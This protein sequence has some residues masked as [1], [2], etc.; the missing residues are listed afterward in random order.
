ME[1]IGLTPGSLIGGYTI[2]APLGSGGMGTVYRAVDGGG[3]PVALKLLHPHVAS[4]AVVRARLMR[5]VAALQRLRHRAVAAVLD[6]EADSTEAFIVTELVAGDTLTDHVRGQGTLDAD[7]LLSLAEGLRSALAAVHAAGVVHRDLKP[8]NVLL[9]DDGPV[10]ID[11]GLAQGLD[12]EANLTTAGFVLGTPGYLAPELLDG[13]EPGP[14]TDLWGWAALL[15]FA[16]TGRDPFGSRPVEAVLAR[17]RAG[18]VDLDGVGPLTR[19]AIAGALRPAPDDRSDPE[20]VVAA[21]RTVAAQ[22]E[23]PPGAVPT[24]ALGTGAGSGAAG[25]AAVAAAV[26][27]AA[28]AAGAA[29]LAGGDDDADGA[30]E[31][32]GADDADD[33]SAGDEA[34]GAAAVAGAATDDDADDGADDDEAD[35]DTDDEAADEAADDDADD[36]PDDDDADDDAAHDDGAGDEPD[37]DAD[38]DEVDDDPDATDDD[39]DADDDVAAEDDPAEDDPAGD[40]VEDDLATELVAQRPSSPQDEMPTVAVGTSPSAAAGSAAAATVAPPEAPVHDGRTVA[41]PVRRTEPAPPA[42][43]VVRDDDAADT[44]VLDDGT[45]PHDPA[46]GV[47]WIEEDLEDPEGYEP[48]EWAYERPPARRRWGSMLALGLVVVLAG[49]LYPVL[50]VAVVLVLAV[51]VRTVGATVEA[52][53]GRRERRGVRRSDAALAALST[54]WYLLRS[55]LGVLPSVL[56]GGAVVLIV[57]GLGWWLLSSQ[58]WAIAGSPPG[59]EPQGQTATLLVG[60]LVAIAVAFLWWGPLSRMTRTGARRTLAAVAPGPVGALVVVVVALVAS[61]LL[62]D[63][64]LDLAPISWW[65]GPTPTLPRP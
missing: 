1:R 36:G 19:A 12:D 65:P 57:G 37:D 50:T 10:L 9:T 27:I 51:V 13:G 32:D 29:A 2:V 56:V 18:E 35:D 25:G 33:A 43:G 22:G 63:R 26:G 64:L 54:P 52:M 15:A 31:P 62:A 5:E 38:D 21:L 42:G 53:Y 16:A 34:A 48:E 30:D 58:R 45:G 14:G 11:F 3:D 23:L 40:W 28:G 24:L 17:A 60:G 61:V 47:D 59:Q 46:E 20:D 7:E 39:G 44:A 49:M 55:V 8:S 41:V 6:A 4:D